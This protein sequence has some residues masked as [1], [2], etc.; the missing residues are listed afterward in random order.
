MRFEVGNGSQ[1]LFWQDVW[2]GETTLKAMFLDLFT[3][4][5]AKEALVEENMA[6]V[7]G[8]IHWNV[9]LIRLVH[10][11]ELEEVS[12]FFELLYSQQ[13]RHGE[14]DYI[15]WIPSKRKNFEVKSYYKVKAN[16]E[17]VDGPWKSKVLTKVAFSGGQRRWGKY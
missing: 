2:C 17:P 7:N 12:R 6:I 13:I 1:V 14:M 11:R 10:D 3:I 16:S 15:C 9:L 5:C 4:A 8:A